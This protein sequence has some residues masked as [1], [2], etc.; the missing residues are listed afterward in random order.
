MTAINNSFQKITQLKCEHTN[1]TNYV[2]VSKSS[3]HRLKI[4]KGIVYFDTATQIVKMKTENMALD[5]KAEWMEMRHCLR[6]QYAEEHKTCNKNPHKTHKCSKR[7]KQIRMYKKKSF[8]FLYNCT[9][10]SMFF[11]IKA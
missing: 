4:E 9:K 5:C 7:G 3:Y 11:E 10:C 1:A 2:Q 6:T 8:F